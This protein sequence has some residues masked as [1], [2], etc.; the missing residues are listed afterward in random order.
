MN[1]DDLIAVRAIVAE[2]T[3]TAAARALRVAQPA[4]SRRF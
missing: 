1:L 3:F 2:G 4:L